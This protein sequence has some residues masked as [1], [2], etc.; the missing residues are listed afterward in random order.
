[1][2]TLAVVDLRDAVGAEHSPGD[3]RGKPTFLTTS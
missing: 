3:D 2:A 1:M